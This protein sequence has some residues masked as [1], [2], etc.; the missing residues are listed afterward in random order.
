MSVLIGSW[1][2]EVNWNILWNKEEPGLVHFLFKRKW[3]FSCSISPECLQQLLVTLG[4]G[5]L[6]P[7]PPSVQLPG[8]L[9]FRQQLMLSQMS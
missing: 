4:R 3:S 1:K 2:N 6:G 9:R 8:Q 7:L 5:R